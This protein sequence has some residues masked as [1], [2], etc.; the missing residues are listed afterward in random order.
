MVELTPRFGPEE[1]QGVPTSETPVPAA[2]GGGSSTPQ[3]TA[4]PD[5]SDEIHVEAQVDQEVMDRLLSE[6]MPER[7]ARAKAKAHYV[8]SERDRIR[9]ER[10]G[11]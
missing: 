5:R 6:G 10:A 9:A 8:R 4:T 3:A 7:V 1:P 11:A 2:A